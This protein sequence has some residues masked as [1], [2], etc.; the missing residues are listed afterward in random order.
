[1]ERKRILIVDDNETNLK[2]FCRLLSLPGYDLET[3]TTAKLALEVVA[4]FRPQLILLDVQLPDIDGLT[5]ARMLKGNEQT[6]D[7][8]IIAVTAYAMKGDEER[9]RASGVD[10]Y[11]TKPIDKDGFRRTVAKYLNPG[12]PH[13]SAVD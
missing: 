4:S 8:L 13:A 6:R 1:M 11:L 5:L 7:I 12:G 3:A 10:D 2:L 9:A